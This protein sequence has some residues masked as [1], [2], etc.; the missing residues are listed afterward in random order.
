MRLISTGIACGLLAISAVCSAK[1]YELNMSTALTSNS[2]VVHA[3]HQFQKHIAQDTNGQLTVHIFPSG[4]LGSTEDVMGQAKNGANVAVLVDPGRLADYEKPL[5]VLSMPYIVNNYKDFGKIARSSLFKGWSNELAK[6]SGFKL[7]GFNWYQGARQLFTQKPVRKPSDLQGVRMRTIATPIW[8]K[9]IRAMGAKPAPMPWT[10]V[11]SA[12]Q[13]GS[14]DAAEAQMTAAYGQHLQDV[15]KYVTLT[16]HILLI[17]GFVTSDSWFQSLPKNL[18]RTLIDDLRQAGNAASK[19]IAAAD[20]EDRKKMEADGVKILK[21]NVAPF[22]KRT[23]KVYS[24][25]G[26]V[27]DRKKIRQILRGQGS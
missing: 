10:S 18:Q 3:L 15:T 13:I 1:S 9:T 6:K 26:Y 27:K 7:L 21:V 5:G 22:R 17:S 23:E 8:I 25:L 11:Y 19:G 20:K 12:L 14:I 24:E 2:P 16:H 4:Q